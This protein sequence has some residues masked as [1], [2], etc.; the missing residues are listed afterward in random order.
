MRALFFLI[1]FSV[2]NSSFSQASTAQKTGIDNIVAYIDSDKDQQIHKFSIAA[3]K[4]VLLPIKYSYWTKAGKITKI[5]RQ[6]KILNDSTEQ[7]FYFNNNQLVY[8]TENIMTYYVEK[9]VSDSILWGGTYYFKSGKL[10][11]IRTLGHGKSESDDWN[12]QAEVLLNSKN[13]KIDIK[14]N[15]A[16]KNGG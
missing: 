13:A 11:D 6:F 5:I 8:S 12:P 15:L 3:D 9:N 1:A 2:S 4:K 7:T 14:R 10:I 16:R